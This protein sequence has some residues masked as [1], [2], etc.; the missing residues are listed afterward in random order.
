VKILLDHNLDWRLYRYL[1]NH[2]V[3]SVLKMGWAELENGDLLDEAEREGF[4]VMLTADKNIK[5]QQAMTGRS[6][7]LVVLRAWNNAIESHV[8]MI[9]EVERV[10]TTIKGGEVVEVL[11]PDMK[12]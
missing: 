2:E 4:A 12:P 11:H 1:P 9:D 6:I 5:K 10:F 8:V 7:A 3:K